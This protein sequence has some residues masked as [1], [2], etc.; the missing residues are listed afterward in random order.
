MS[1]IINEEALKEKDVLKCEELSVE[2]DE[3]CIVEERTIESS[4]RSRRKTIKEHKLFKPMSESKKLDKFMAM[5]E[6]NGFNK[7]VKS[8]MEHVKAEEQIIEVKYVLK[9]FSDE[10][11]LALFQAVKNVTGNCDLTKTQEASGEKVPELIDI[12]LPDGTNVKIPWGRVALPN[13]DVSG[14]AKRRQTHENKNQSLDIK[15][16]ITFANK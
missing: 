13:F 16:K 7:A 8:M 5:V 11:A 2:K 15:I 9:C 4:V 6:E 3:L 14:N 12:E 1:K 10:G